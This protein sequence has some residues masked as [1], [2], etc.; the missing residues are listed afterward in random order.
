MDFGAFRAVFAARA[1]SSAGSYI[2]IV[3]ATW[4]VYSLTG[5][6]TAVG[7]LSALALGPAIVGGPVGG[8][9][10][11][12]YDPR[13][14]SIVLS[15]LQAIPAGAMAILAGADV[16]TVPW[17][18]VLVF[19]G[20]VPFSLNQPVITLVVPYTVPEEFRHTAV[21]RASMIYNITRLLGSVVGGFLVDA[22]GVGAAFAI[23]SASYA[24]VAVVLWRI[25]LVEQPVVRRSTGQSIGA[26]L[27]QGWGMQVLRATGIGLAV[28]FTLVA[29]VEQLMPSVAQEHGFDAS[30]VG[31]L[32]GA[33]A[34]GALL[35]NPFVGRRN[36]S[37]AGRRRLMA[38]GLLLAAPGLILLG[39]TPRHGLPIDVVAAVLIGFGWEFVFVSG[40]ATV[41]V[42]T[43]A[44]IRGS[45]MGVFFVLVTAT[46][47]LGAVAVGFLIE[48]LGLLNAFLVA[49]AIVVAAG[50]VLYVVSRRTPPDSAAH[51]ADSVGNVPGQAA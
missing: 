37:A 45:M 19:A 22:V 14:L 26:G 2:Q 47:A 44:H 48:N 13:H 42:E 8:S 21:A 23:N 50:V 25:T 46:T 9:L 11:D 33:I 7:V 41:A 36:D 5:S 51:D 40:Q 3:A 20:A 35:A 34:V 17:L 30:D 10:A 43:A 32:V 4:Y 27:R 6:A 31:I 38:Y 28:F 49:A 12:R 24:F 18:Y 29:P 39:V 15:V 1:V 16:L